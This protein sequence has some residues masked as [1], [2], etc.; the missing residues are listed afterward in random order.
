MTVRSQMKVR[1]LSVVGEG[2]WLCV[3]TSV[4]CTV[5]ETAS[6]CTCAYVGTYVLAQ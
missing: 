5:C 1:M 2:V 6:V 3:Y 4:W